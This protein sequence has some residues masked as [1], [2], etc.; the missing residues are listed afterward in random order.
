MNRATER[1]VLAQRQV[2]PDLVVVGRIGFDDL[3]Q[4]V[5]TEHHDVVEALAADRA[6]EPFDIAVLPGRPRRRWPVTNAHGAEPV[7][8]DL[9]IGRIPI[10]DQT[11]RQVI[12]R[13][14]LGDLSGDP[15]L[16][17]MSDNVEEQQLPTLV[18]KDDQTIKKSNADHGTTRR[19]I[20]AIPA[21]WLR[22]KVLHL[23][24]SGHPRLAIYLAT[25]D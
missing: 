18:T 7:C 9:T 1:C 3:A 25:V 8:N 5:L 2:C 20:A 17:G 10:T 23:C 22:R 15:F 11:S 12:P 4:M 19:Y 24:E 21:A 13:Q 14:S 6:D 16:G